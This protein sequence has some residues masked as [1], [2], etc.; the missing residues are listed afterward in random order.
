MEDVGAGQSSH[1]RCPQGTILVQAQAAGHPSCLE[2]LLGG[3]SVAVQAA[4]TWGQRGAKLHPG[5]K[6]R[7]SGGVPGT[8][9]TRV[10]RL[11]PTMVEDSIPA[12]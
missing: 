7:R 6:R 2:T 8:A 3:G 5:S 9:A 12:V 11:W 1:G 4:I 10:P